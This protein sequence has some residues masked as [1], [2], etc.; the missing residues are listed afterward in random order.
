MRRISVG[1]NFT[2]FALVLVSLR[3]TCCYVA[4][5]RCSVQMEWTPGY[6]SL[7]AEYKLWKE[8]RSRA[9]WELVEAEEEDN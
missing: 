1:F 2:N 6:S 8:R 9:G 3:M 7:K 4:L 5:L